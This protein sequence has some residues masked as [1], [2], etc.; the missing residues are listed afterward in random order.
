MVTLAV[1]FV[2]GS[3]RTGGLG[4]RVFIGVLLGFMFSLMQTG[5]GYYS[6]SFGISP[7]ITALT[8]AILFLG[9]TGFLFYRAVRIN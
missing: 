4:R 8:P 6:L 7:A 3:I 9:L 5:M 2:F 1:P